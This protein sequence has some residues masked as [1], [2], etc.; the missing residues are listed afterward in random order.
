MV[1][2]VVTPQHIS[3]QPS[4]QLGKPGPLSLR[5]V[6][7]PSF[8]LSYMGRSCLLLAPVDG[9]TDSYVQSNRAALTSTVFLQCPICCA[10]AVLQHTRSNWRANAFSS[11]HFSGKQC[12]GLQ[13]PL[14][15]QPKPAT[16]ATSSSTCHQLDT[17]HDSECNN[18]ILLLKTIGRP[19]IRTSSQCEGAG[20]PD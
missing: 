13:Q 2:S 15:Q 6:L 12:A 20:Q 4:L 18:T 14:L 3:A 7:S 19:W 8:S 16:H 9:Q 11:T 17:S 10:C 5:A 1:S